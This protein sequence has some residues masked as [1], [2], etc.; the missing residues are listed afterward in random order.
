MKV[1]ELVPTNGRKSFGGKCKVIETDNK[2]ELL[3]YNTIVASFDKISREVVINGEYSNTTNI[4][5]KEFEKFLS[6][7]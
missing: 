1:F 6:V 2:M 4:H 5:I 3:S 7:F